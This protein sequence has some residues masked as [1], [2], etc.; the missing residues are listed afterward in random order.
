MRT[1]WHPRSSAHQPAV[2][3]A[4]PRVVDVCAGNGDG[5]A[6]GSEPFATALGGVGVPAEPVEPPTTLG[7]PDAYETVTLVSLTTNDKIALVACTSHPLELCAGVPARLSTRA[8][9]RTTPAFTERGF[10]RHT[11]ACAPRS[12][13]FASRT[14]LV[15]RTGKIA[16]PGALRR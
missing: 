6:A 5:G 7:T 4:A 16:G 1:T 9:C 13:S 15:G 10:I 11:T 8:N 12:E 2:L 14:Y 3:S